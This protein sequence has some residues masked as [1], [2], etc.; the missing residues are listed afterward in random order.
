MVHNGSLPARYPGFSPRQKSVFRQ[1]LG[2]V[3]A[4]V[5]TSEELADWFRTQHGFQ[6]EIRM[7][8]PLLPVEGRA[9]EAGPLPAVVT[10][11]V[12]QYEKKVVSVGVFDQAYGF[13]QIVRVVEDLRAGHGL[14]IGLLLIDCTFTNDPAYEKQITTGRDWVVPVAQLSNPA[15]GAV[16]EQCDAFVRATHYESYGLSRV[17]ALFSGLPVVA[18]DVGETRGM[19]L[20]QYGDLEG[21]RSQL[22]R[23][24][25]SPPEAQIAE[26]ADYYRRQ[27]AANFAKLMAVLED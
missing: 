25:F 9:E 19:L 23:A 24:L 22:E 15:V 21:L 17:E 20:Y 7:I 18:T 27:A 16:M 6:K 2:Q 10:R 12:R 4:L 8:G 5:T 1:M 14:D 3:D 11:F 26:G 13:D